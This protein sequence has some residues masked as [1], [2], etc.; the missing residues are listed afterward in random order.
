M[1]AEQRTSPLPPCPWSNKKQ[2]VSAEM[3]KP[4][5]LFT[6]RNVSMFIIKKQMFTFL[7]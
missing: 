1:L 6:E 2:S 7:K 4:F 3:E 5:S